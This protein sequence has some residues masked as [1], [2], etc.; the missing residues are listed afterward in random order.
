MSICQLCDCS[1]LL[2]SEAK[3]FVQ[4]EQQIAQQCR[5]QLK[6]LKWWQFFAKRRLLTKLAHRVYNIDGVKI[7][8]D[9]IRQRNV[10]SSAD[11]QY[12]NCTCDTLI[13]YKF[14]YIGLTGSQAGNKILWPVRYKRI[15]ITN[16]MMQFKQPD[17]AVV[18][19]VVTR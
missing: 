8:F 2:Q 3:L 18:Y 6:D 12:K 16:A 5:D 14:C 15:T 10:Y 7:L 1:N 17:R 13:V 9:G 19:A 11:K 4:N